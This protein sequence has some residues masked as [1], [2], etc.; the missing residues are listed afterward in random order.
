MLPKY[1]IYEKLLYAQVVAV[2]RDKTAKRRLKFQKRPFQ[3]VSAPLSLHTQLLK[4]KM[5]LRNSGIKI[6]FLEPA[7]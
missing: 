1:A 2:I 5:S 4:W 3:E 6:F 7:L